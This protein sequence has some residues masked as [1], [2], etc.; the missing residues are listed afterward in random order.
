MEALVLDG[1]NYIKASKAAR[2]LGYATDYVG[3]LCRSG[4]VSAHLI[5]RTWYVNQEELSHHRVEKKRMSR[6][7]AREHAK[8][9]IEEHRLKINSTPNPHKDVAISYESDTQDLIPRTKKI[10]IESE[11]TRV[12]RVASEDI[13]D[14]LKVI[15]RGNTV[16]MSGE[17]EVIDLSDGVV[18]SETTV[19]TPT[20]RRSKP[21]ISDIGTTDTLQTVDESISEEVNSVEE[22][23]RPTFEERLLMQQEIVSPTI[24]ASVPNVVP[25]RK[26]TGSM[27][28]YFFILFCVLI[29]SAGSVALLHVIHFSNVDGVTSSEIRIIVNETIELI[30]SKI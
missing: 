17:L 16:A 28:P 11:A 24:E 12:Q 27:Y 4:Q 3:Q 8:K 5:G 15:N 6:V 21:A 14:D 9:T 7:K 29:L 26:T 18:D 22:K 25:E 10:H 1:K 2:D 23:S 13:G 19:L 20:I 30:R